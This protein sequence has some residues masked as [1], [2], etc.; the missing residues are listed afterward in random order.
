LAKEVRGIVESKAKEFGVELKL[1]IDPD[2]GNFEADHKAVR[3]SLVNILENSLDACRVDS[4]KTSHTVTLSLKDE[5][6]DVSFV[7]S[8]NGIGMDQETR[9]KA[10]SLF[11]SSKGSEGT[12][13]GLFIANKIAQKHGGKIVLESKLGEGSSFTII[14]P[15]NPLPPEKTDMPEDS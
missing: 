7:I 4:S 12:G 5:G 1:E 13:L 15:K 14:F 11:F 2:A 6:D 8:D 3:S 9:E 10:F